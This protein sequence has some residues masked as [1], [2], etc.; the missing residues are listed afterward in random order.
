M[1]NKTGLG[2]SS[3]IIRAE[4]CL[5]SELAKTFFRRRVKISIKPRDVLLTQYNL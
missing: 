4:N 2:V 3:I 1:K 5:F